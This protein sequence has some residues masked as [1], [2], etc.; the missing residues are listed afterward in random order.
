MK[1]NKY[2]IIILSLFFVGVLSSC[3]IGKKY[4][5]P[6]LNLPAEIVDFLLLLCRF[7]YYNSSCHIGKI[8]IEL[9]SVIH[10]DEVTVFDGL[11]GWNTVE[12]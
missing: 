5:R 10:Q 8:T 9:A 3:K 11:A 12:K 1:Q 6:E 7:S 2:I 4:S